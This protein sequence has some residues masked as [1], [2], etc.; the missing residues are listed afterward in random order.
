MV[1]GRFTT[2][3]TECFSQELVSRWLKVLKQETVLVVLC[4]LLKQSFAFSPSVVLGYK[5]IWKSK[6]RNFS[7]HWNSLPTL[8]YASLY[9]HSCLFSL[10]T[11]LI[12]VSYPGKWYICQSWFPARYRPLHAIFAFV[13]SL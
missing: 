2:E 11:F 3:T 10:F 1:W 12:L 7:S 4:I 8:A 6:C 5:S 13:L 9:F